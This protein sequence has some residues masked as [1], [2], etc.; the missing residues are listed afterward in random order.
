[1]LVPL[2]LCLFGFAD[3]APKPIEVKLVKRSTPVSYAKEIADILDAKCVG[4]HSAAL[5]EGKLILEDVAAIRKGGKHGPAIVSGKAVDSLLFKMAAHRVVPV[6]P[7]KD[8]KDLAPLTPEELGLLEQWINSGAGDDRIAVAATS[9]PIEIGTLPP[10]VHPINAVDLTSDG[11]TVAAGRANLVQ[12][13]DVDSGIEVI[14]LGGHKDLIQS[15]RFSPDA[16]KL[17]AGGYQV[18]TVWN[19]PTSSLD[20]TFAVSPGA[21]KAIVALRDGK[22]LITGGAEA[23]LRFWNRSDGKTSRTV[24]LP[25]GV[26]SLALSPDETMLATGDSA[27]TIRLLNVA[28]GKGLSEIKESAKA[29]SSVVFIDAKT[30]LSRGVDGIARIS[31]LPAK[32]GDKG[33]SRS[34]G[35]GSKSPVRFVI[36]SRD[37]KTILT[38]SDDGFVRQ[39]GLEDGKEVRSFGGAGGPVLAMALSPDGKSILV[40]SADGSARLHEL[41]SGRLI[42][43]FGPL[44]APILDVAFAPKGDRILTAGSDGGVKVWDVATRR[45]VVAFGQP[46]TSPGRV[47]RAMFLDDGR[48][49]TVVGTTMKIWKFEGSW[50]DATTLGPHAFRVLAIDFSPDGKLIATGGGEPSRSGEVMIWEAATGKLLRRLDTLHSDTVFALKFSP[51]GSKLA[52]ASADKF[53]KVINVS[54]GKEL[55]SFEGH[56]NH[57]LTV[58][59]RADGKQLATGGADNVIK[60]WDFESG[61]GLRTLNPSTKQITS[62]RWVPGKPMVVG[63]SGDTNVRVWNPDNG[64][65]PR[66]FAG[67]T[68][69]VFAVAA[70]VD[71]GRVAAGGADGVLFLWNGVNGQSIRKLSPSSSSKSPGS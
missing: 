36:P 37:G 49:A 14:S 60:V 24:S 66:T 44:A 63:A 58:D 12:V 52:T 4:C 54:E 27:G 56:T 68:D 30:L 57:V 48:V 11:R 50:S 21:I 2:L 26:E 65:I 7:P 67:P 61:E 13:Y 42:A 53:L 55:K 69:Y 9:K 51:D 25:T 47:A 46:T 38:G 17:A 39:F 16:R 18:V 8:K 70:S 34:L 1:M 64:T 10:G 32:T 19:A 3:D 35:S 45:G 41:A 23:A 28:D 29:I 40:G 33:T 71:G 43:T 15:L 6:M 62:I 31:I 22:T 59:W 20:K 5:S